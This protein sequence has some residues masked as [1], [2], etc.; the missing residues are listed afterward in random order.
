MSCDHKLHI[1]I[2]FWRNYESEP[3]HRLTGHVHRLLA[4]PHRLNR[5]KLSAA[6]GDH[7]D[8]NAAKVIAMWGIKRLLASKGV[9]NRAGLQG[10]C[11]VGKPQ[12]GRSNAPYA[13]SDGGESFG[14]QHPGALVLT[15]LTIASAGWR[16]ETQFNLHFGNS[17][18][19]IK[20]VG[21]SLYKAKN[22]SFAR[23][24]AT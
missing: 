6:N 15:E 23:V 18:S 2:W 3:P 9:K 24:I 10:I 21:T 1:E 11:R 17:A 13:W 5:L 16:G 14:W 7:P 20:G 12:A 8:N 19:A 22:R 4:N